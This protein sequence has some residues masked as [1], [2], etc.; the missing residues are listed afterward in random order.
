MSKKSKA[1]ERVAAKMFQ[2]VQEGI[3]DAVTG[4]PDLP[5]EV[6][7]TLL[8]DSLPTRIFNNTH[9]TRSPVPQRRRRS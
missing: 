4:Y 6:A 7:Q 1:S 2:G 3:L 9:T 5:R 8:S